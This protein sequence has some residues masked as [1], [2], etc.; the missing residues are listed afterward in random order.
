MGH[1]TK[2]LRRAPLSCFGVL[3]SLNN[4]E[5]LQ[6]TKGTESNFVFFGV[7]FC[8]H[9]CT[10]GWQFARFCVCVEEKCGERVDT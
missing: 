10:I 6:I 8:P 5:E 1:V 3:K 4:P 2:V 9:Q 7:P